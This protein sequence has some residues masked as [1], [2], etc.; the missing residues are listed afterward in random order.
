M[1]TVLVELIEDR[2]DL[3]AVF[4][5]W[6]HV[7]SGLEQREIFG[8]KC[9]LQFVYLLGQILGF[10]AVFLPINLIEV[11]TEIED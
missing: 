9:F 4:G 5:I 11:I 7:L 3:L 8:A 1:R 10:L 2:H 6:V